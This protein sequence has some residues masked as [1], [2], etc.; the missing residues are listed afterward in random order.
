MEPE[1]SEGVDALGQ[2]VRHEQALL[3]DQAQDKLELKLRM[4]LGAVRLRGARL[5]RHAVAAFGGLALAAAALA[6]VVVWRWPRP[7]VI[8]FTVG[9]HAAS[10]SDWV[11]TDSEHHASLE[12]SEG[13]TVLARPSSRVRVSRLNAGGALVELERGELAVSVQH[14]EHTH[15]VFEA[16]AY[17]VEVIGTRFDLA[18]SPVEERFEI[19]MQDGRVWLDGP[20]LER[21]SVVAGE[22]VVF[23]P[24]ARDTPEAAPT[25]EVSAPVEQLT[26]DADP[27]AAGEA[28][29][30]GRRRHVTEV[31]SPRSWAEL[32]HEGQYAA[33]LAAAEAEGFERLCARLEV[34]ALQEL[35]DMARFAG[36]ASRARQAYVALRERFPGSPLA[37]RAAFDLGVMGSLDGATWF[38][39]Y[40]EEAPDGPLAREA[41]GR[42][43]EL[44]HRAGRQVDARRLARTY[45]ER[46]PE[47]A[48]A[49]LARSIESDP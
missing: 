6:L 32:A 27:E 3:L 17:R 8:S 23:E 15:W 20:H 9:G 12:F 40:L 24:S 38:E 1:R 25:P 44:R 41:M 39:T 2:M 10:E 22:R 43:L 4:S 11:T 31:R 37:S 26:A 5:R 16:G 34:D 33:A 19:S 28:V 36:S 18:W 42:L 48:H 14:H 49:R 35:G 45:L 7:Q 47:G 30:A 13:T 21:R 29:P 46:Y